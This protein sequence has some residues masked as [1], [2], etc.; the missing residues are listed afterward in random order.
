MLLEKLPFGTPVQVAFQRD[1]FLESGGW[2]LRLDV[3]DDIDSW[4][5]IAQFGDALFINQRMAYRTLWSGGYNQY[6]S[7]QKRL[8]S[9]LMIKDKIYSLI[10]EKYIGVVP[11]LSD[12]HDYL[13]LYWSVV[14]LK[15]KNFVTFLN[16]AFPS[17]LSIK[18]WKLLLNA[19]RLKQ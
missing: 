13:K 7:I 15:Q 9:N 12:I 10:N 2:D 8:E 11:P 4:I 5:R 16:L 19:I 1:A 14:A 3:C 18:S 6:S 17:A